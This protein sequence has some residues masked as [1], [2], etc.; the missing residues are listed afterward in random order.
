MDEALLSEA[1]FGF[2]GVYVDIDLFRGHLKE[3]EDDGETGGRN[4]VAVGLSDAVDEQAVADKALVDKDLD[5]V[6][7]VL[8]EFR[9]GVE[10]GEAEVSGI[11]DGLI[12]VFLPGGRLGQAAMGKGTLRGN[13]EQLGEGVF[14]ED[15][16]DAL[17]GAGDGGRGDDGVG[18][19]G[20]LEVFLRMDEGVV[21]DEGGDV[22]EFSAFG[23][24]EFA[25]G[26]GVE[27]E[28]GYG[29]GGSAGEGNVVDVEDFAAGDFK[30]GS[31][32]F[33]TGGGIECDAGDGGDG[34]KSFAAEAEG[35]YREEVVGGA[36]FGGGMALEGEQGVVAVH[37]L[38]VVGDADEA[39]A[40]G[41]DLD[42]DAVGAGVESV[43]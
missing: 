34:R 22:T 18:G 6:A 38:A 42:A 20:E 16:V 23:A 41:F 27:E 31:G 12:G 26:G 7:V 25:A 13:W 17:G 9:L 10:A 30:V 28:V 2:G 35:G 39:A 37:A 11:A 4:D 14:A 19:G 36:K 29:D 15:L 32:G 5:G 24:E 43:L 8:L 21:G 33:V 40:T 1:D 3:Q